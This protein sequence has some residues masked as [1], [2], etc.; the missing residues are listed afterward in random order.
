MNA[1]SRDLFE[2]DA[3]D[4][5]AAALAMARRF[6]SGA[7]LWCATPAAPRHAAQMADELARRAGAGA[8]VLRAAAVPAGPLLENLR[9]LARGGDMLLL[10][11]GPDDPSVAG[12]R[13]RAAAWGVLTIWAG[14]GCRPEPG[15]ADYVLWDDEATASPGPGRLVALAS[16]LSALVRDRLTYPELLEPGQAG[17]EDEVCITCSDEGRLGEVVTVSS[18]FEAEVRTPTGTETVDTS[19]I[20]DARTGDVV[21]IHARSALRVVLRDPPAAGRERSA[22]GLRAGAGPQS[23]ETEEAR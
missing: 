10:A 8:P 13:E 15:A 14:A 3:E 7:T 23:S 21:L 18:T 20:D 2:P 6:A 1:V 9:T 12:L 22:A 4:V 16:L 5:S 19:L 11:T 17:C